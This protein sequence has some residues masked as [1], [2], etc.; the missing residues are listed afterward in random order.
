MEYANRRGVPTVVVIG[1]TEIETGKLTVK[2][3]ATG[4]QTTLSLTELIEN[5]K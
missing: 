2:T 1:E 3:M 4:E 5:Y